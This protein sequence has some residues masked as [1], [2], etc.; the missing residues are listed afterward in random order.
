M[1]SLQMVEPAKILLY[2]FGHCMNSHLLNFEKL[3]G[4]LVTGG[5]DVTLLIPTRYRGPH[6]N[7]NFTGVKLIKFWS[8]EDISDICTFHSLQTFLE[9]SLHDIVMTFYRSTHQFCDALLS[10]KETMSSIK[11]GDFDLAI[12][13]AVDPCSRLLADYVD[14]PFIVFHTQGIENIQ[15]RHPAYMPSMLTTYSDN[16]NLKQRV[17]NTVG[18]L[19]QK[20]I[21]HLTMR[22]YTSLRIKHQVN[23][24]LNLAESFNRAS[25]RLILGDYALDYVGPIHP[26]HVLI[27]GSIQSQPQPIPTKLLQFVEGAEGRGV[28]VLSFGSMVKYYGPHWREVFASALARLP[29]RVIWRYN[30]D[31]PESLGNNTMLVPWLPQSDLLTHPSIR[32]FI[33]HAGINAAFE[34]ASNGV[35]IVAI[36]LFGDQ[37]FQ[38]TKLS[39]HAKMGVKLNVYA[40]TQD[41]IYNAITKV[42][43]NEMY[44]SNANKVA[45]IINTKPISQDK[46]ILHWVSAVLNTNG[47]AYLQS[48]EF[49]LAWYQYFLLDVNLI[50]L[51]CFLISLY[52]LKYIITCLFKLW[53]Y[54][55]IVI[56]SFVWKN[57]LGLLINYTKTSDCLHVDP[58]C[59]V[60]S[61]MTCQETPEKK[62]I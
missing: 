41:V 36:P 14:V 48:K 33:T 29:M 53:R 38:A 4:L 59:A 11:R 1:S 43:S 52:V 34:A 7:T 16:M 21:L 32:V 51:F 19:A 20:L 57:I 35:P 13:D 22:Y 10:D 31:P 60:L 23:A 17:L 58:N 56:V 6:A 39:E 40:L 44:T 12:Y 5:H 27:G 50:I 45:H 47:A 49:S 26:S 9:T 55:I 42:I 3:A 54:M 18:Y 61:S 28:A 8:P 46:H 62:H 30:E 24:T 37:N 15:P 25:L 2:P